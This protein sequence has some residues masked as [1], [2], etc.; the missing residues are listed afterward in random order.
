MNCGSILDALGP[1]LH[2]VR[3]SL[4]KIMAFRP[5]RTGCGVRVHQ[6][7]HRSK[8]P[9]SPATF[10]ISAPAPWLRL[11]PPARTASERGMRPFLHCPGSRHPVF[12]QPPQPLQAFST[13]S[14]D[15]SQ[16]Q[17][18]NRRWAGRSIRSS[19]HRHPLPH[20][21]PP[22]IPRPTDSAAVSRK[23]RRSSCRVSPRQRS[24][25]HKQIIHSTRK[26]Y[27]VQER[28]MALKILGPT[29]SCIK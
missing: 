10:C 19:S 11:P 1:S 21:E 8:R 12:R 2:Q 13:S 9:P 4:L 20:L 7:S 23:Q 22:P 5:G 27:F 26:P 28:R 16:R 18:G 3:V 15:V 24:P 17:T 14:A 6:R 25:L 29:P